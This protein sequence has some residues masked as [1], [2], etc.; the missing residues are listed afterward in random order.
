MYIVS[1]ANESLAHSLDVIRANPIP[2]A[3]IGLGVAWLIANNTGMTDRVTDTASDMGR[4]VTDTASDMSRRASELATG[5][6]QKVGLAGSGDRALGHTGH[7]MV[8]RSGEH[9]EGWVHQVSDQASGALRSARDTSG[10]ILNRVGSYA[11]A[12]GVSDTFERNPLIIGAIGVMT[13][14]LIAALV[15]LS[16]VENELLGETRDDLWHRAEDL[17]EEAVQRVRD[18]ATEAA[19]RAVDAA[20]GAAVESVRQLGEKSSQ[21]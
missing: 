3:L 21:S 12:G 15:P 14:A 16:E 9:S 7:P 10:A 19:V 8:D 4:R 6:A 11:G 20:T 17:G 13:G 5:A 2:V 1:N 18:A